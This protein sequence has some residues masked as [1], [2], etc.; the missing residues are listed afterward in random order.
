M[1]IVARS[2]LKTFWETY[3]DSKAGLIFW[4]EKMSAK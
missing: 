4:Y 1:R 2:T 3:I